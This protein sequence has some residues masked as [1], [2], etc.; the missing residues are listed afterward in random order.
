MIGWYVHHHGRGHVHRAATIA[1]QLRTPVV[2][3]ST[4]PAPEGWTGEWVRL[5]ADADGSAPR[6]PT[7]GGVLHWAPLG[8]PG[9]RKRMALISEVLARPELRLVVVDVSVEVALLA[10]LSGLPVVVVAQPGD[11]TDRPHRTAY[12]LAGKLLAPWPPAGPPL[13]DRG[14][15]VGAISRF[16]DREPPPPPGRRRVLVLWGAGGTDVSPGDL[17][18][19][20]TATPG[21]TWDVVGPGQERPGPTNL[22]WR[23]W[24]EDVWA[25]LCDA[26]VVV[27]HGGQNAVAE[28][29][30]AR[31]AAVVV[32]QDRPHEE[33]HTTAA[34]L[35]RAGI[36]VVRSRWPVP[37]L[38]PS[39]LDEAVARGGEGWKHWSFGDGAARAA[40][41]LDELA[42]G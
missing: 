34:A 27:T 37:G 30:A 17:H 25:A 40:A 15:H 21:W 28:V 4:L 33:Q 38:W 20:A 5:A 32:S 36:A 18:A 14:V 8:H 10:R 9:L 23:G 2:G 41:V 19:A 12:D 42:A 13:P 16:D 11:R 1:A 26:D 35:G 29:A 3:L 31:R 6:D 7:A 24:C 39:V 22:R